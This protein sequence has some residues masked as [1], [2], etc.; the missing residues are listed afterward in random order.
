MHVERLVEKPAQGESE[1]EWNNARLSRPSRYLDY[2]TQLAPSPRGEL[3]PQAIAAMIN[4]GREVRAI[5]MR[6]FWSDV[7]T[8]A[9]LEV[10]RKRFHPKRAVTRKPKLI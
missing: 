3:M 9:D 7:G 2:L 10:A 5:D 6:G 8:P 1:T 4:D